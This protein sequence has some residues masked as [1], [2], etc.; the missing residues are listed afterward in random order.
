MARSDTLFENVYNGAV[1]ITGV[2]T[3]FTITYADVP[4]ADCVN[5]L[6]NSSG[7]SSSIV[8]LGTSTLNFD[9]SQLPIDGISADQAC[10]SELSN[11]LEWTYR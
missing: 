3:R 4:Q 7:Q 2:G 5:I 11:T 1:D 9:A 6:I 8:S 10:D